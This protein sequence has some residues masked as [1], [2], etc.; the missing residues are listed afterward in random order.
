MTEFL[1][2]NE[3]ENVEE[4]DGGYLE[5]LSR[6]LPRETEENLNQDSRYPEQDL[7]RYLL[8]TGQ[9]SFCLS[10]LVQLAAMFLLLIIRNYNHTFMKIV[11]WDFGH[12]SSF[13]K[14]FS[15]A[16]LRDSTG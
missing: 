3:L 12:R 11:L 13:F 14:G 6:N 4:S 1:L 15:V 8:N 10:Q 2:N 5:V 9:T 7:N 16:V